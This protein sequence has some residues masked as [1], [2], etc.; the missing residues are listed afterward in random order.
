MT[1]PD[2]LSVAGYELQRLLG[3][4]GMATV[5]LGIE[6]ATGRRVAIK[7]LAKGKGDEAAERRF[8]MEG[9]TL[10]RL[11]HPNIVQV[12]EVM[13][14]EERSYIVMECLEGGVLSKR[15]ATGWLTLAD[16]VGFMV[17]I[18]G[19]LQY[20]HEHGVIH[21]DLKPDNILFRDARTPVLTDF[22]IARLR[23]DLTDSRITET[24][25]VIGTPTYMSPE[26]ATGSEVDGRSDQYALGVLFYEM[27]AG[28]PPFVGDTAMQIAF[29]HVHQPPPSLPVGN[30][31][32]EPLI[33]RMLSK[34]PAD[35]FPDL[36]AFVAE[37]K[38][39]LVGSSVVQK[40][41]NLDPSTEITDQLKAIGF[42][43]QQLAAKIPR[44]V[45]AVDAPQG[46]LKHALLEG[47]ALALEPVV[48][49]RKEVRE[50]KQGLIPAWM[51][52][53]LIVLLLIGMGVAVV[54]MVF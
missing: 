12:L 8:L 29:A 1:I 16:H 38:S 30:E 47:S 18:A 11:P 25:M 51:K 48:E 54:S 36:R 20:A 19:A 14:E 15:M 13:H 45:L 3:E 33:M 52:I 7:L 17:Q 37:M 27:L 26:Q 39:S 40:R 50:E 4:G 44:T 49:R 34:K 2:N 10:A 31:F 53:L 28:K 43:D 23:R 46:S 9:E 21:R 35:R 22:G 24:G 42:S 5:W 32:V 41:L 6:V